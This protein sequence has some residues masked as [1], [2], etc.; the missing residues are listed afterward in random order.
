MPFNPTNRSQNEPRRNH[1]SVGIPAVERDEEIM[2][3]GE[4]RALCAERGVRPLPRQSWQQWCEV[5]G[6]K[7]TF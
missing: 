6:I 5:I 7:M 1:S 4:Y 3:Y 2:S